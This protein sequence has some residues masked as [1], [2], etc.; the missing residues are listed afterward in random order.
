MRAEPAEFRKL[1]LRCHSLLADVPLHDVWA[2]SLDGGGPGRTMLDVRAISPL[3][4]GSRHPVVRALVAVRL[5]LGRLLGWDE[6][7]HEH[8][9]ESYLH[10]LSE[11]DRARSKV[12]PGTP[13]GPFRT[14]Y[15][16]SREALFEVRNATV[17]AFL[18]TALVPLSGRYLLYWAVYVRLVGGLTPVYMTLIDPFRR[19]VVYP[20]LRRELQAT[21]SRTYG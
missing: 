10:R 17:H 6:E 9:G 2:V 19:L 13:E 11:E 12:P 1:E 14:I 3:D 15:L 8:P 21:W 4:L 5:G 16:F 18:A 20:A 7:R